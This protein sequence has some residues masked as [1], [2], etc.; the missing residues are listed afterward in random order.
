MFKRVN[1]RALGGRFY[2]DI[3]FQRVSSGM[4]T[5]SLGFP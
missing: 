2:E 3:G 1:S 5:W 4:D